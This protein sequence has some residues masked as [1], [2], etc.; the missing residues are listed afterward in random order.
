M[1]VQKN[2]LP[3]PQHQLALAHRRSFDERYH[4]YLRYL[5]L[6]RGEVAGAACEFALRVGQGAQAK[7][8]FRA[9][10]RVNGCAYPVADSGRETADLYRASALKVAARAEG[11]TP[12]GPPQVRSGREVR[13]SRVT[14]PASGK[15]QLIRVFVD[16]AEA[17]DTAITAY[18]R[19]KVRRYWRL[20]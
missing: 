6:V 10:D 17:V 19:S 4:S 5:L 13:Q 16:S 7:H 18:R 12:A 15:L 1:L 11:Q 2:P 9:G 3:R 20:E 8:A 14:D